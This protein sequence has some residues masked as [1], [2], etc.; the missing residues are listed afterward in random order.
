MKTEPGERGLQQPD[1][2]YLDERFT[3]L[4]F[5]LV[6]F[7]Q[8]TI[9]FEQILRSFYYTSMWLNAE[10][11]NSWGTLHHLQIPTALFIKELR[12]TQ[13]MSIMHARWRLANFL[14]A[15][16]ARSSCNISS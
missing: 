13:N 8:T 9:A 2:R 15:R 4:L 5:S 3:D 12:A 6:I 10:S 1:D 11:T 14:Y 16:I 7:T